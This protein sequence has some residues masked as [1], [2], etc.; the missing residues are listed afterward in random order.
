MNCIKLQTKEDNRYK[1][2]YQESTWNHKVNNVL[3]LTV[4]A[5]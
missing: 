2:I 1:E 3:K 5:C 4:L